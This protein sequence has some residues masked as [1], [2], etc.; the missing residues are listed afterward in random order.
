VTPAGG[1]APLGIT[2]ASNALNIT[3][4]AP[5]APGGNIALDIN[6]AGSPHSGGFGYFVFGTRSGDR[7]AWS[8][9][10]PYGARNWWPCKDH[11][12][13]KAD[14]VRVTITVPSQYRVGSQ[15]V[16]ASETINGGN[17]TYDWV[18]R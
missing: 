15:G 14:S 9:S 3:L 5:V 1:G 16:L 17:T 18:S 13:D 4:P 12:S 6:Y 8:L 11:P 2:H 7:Y 10:E